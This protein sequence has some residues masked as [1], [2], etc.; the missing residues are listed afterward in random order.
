MLTF[1]I[2][3]AYKLIGELFVENRLL[4]KEIGKLGTELEKIKERL[5][6]NNSLSKQGGGE[7]EDQE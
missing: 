5:L 4:K 7:K 6:E 1:D 2:E 3:G